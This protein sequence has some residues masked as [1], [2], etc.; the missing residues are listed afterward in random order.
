MRRKSVA[1]VPCALLFASGCRLTQASGC[2]GVSG[3]DG[4]QSG[5][6]HVGKSGGV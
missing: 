2:W 6:A 4:C 5:Y 1:V 3:S